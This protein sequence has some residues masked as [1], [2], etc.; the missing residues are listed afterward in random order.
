V[1]KVEIVDDVKDTAEMAVDVATMPTFL[2]GIGGIVV[3]ATLGGLIASNIAFKGTISNAL[4]ASGEFLFGA[5]LYGMGLSGRVSHPA[6]RS[7]TQV[8]GVVVAGMGLG[9][10]LSIFGAPTF[11]LGAEIDPTTLGDDYGRMVGQDYH[12]RATGQWSGAAEGEG[13]EAGQVMQGRSQVFVDTDVYGEWV[14]ENV[15]GQGFV[16][17][18]IGQ[19]AEDDDHT[20]TPLSYSPTI[21]DS[22]PKWAKGAS[23]VKNPWEAAEAWDIMAPSSPMGGVPQWWGSAEGVTH[24]AQNTTLG[25]MV[26]GS[27]GVGSV[28]GQ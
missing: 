8:S 20:Y 14:N 17:Q 4:A 12:G 7:A 19:D 22:G 25:N 23:G 6:L 27:E 9:R 3:G 21:T 26:A 11:G 28:I 10:L 2:G 15:T 16:G 1:R 5:A 13:E 18:V 24:S